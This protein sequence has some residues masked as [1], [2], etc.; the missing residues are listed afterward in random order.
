MP[1]PLSAVP[2][3]AEAIRP[4]G[5]AMAPGASSDEEAVA[6]AAAHNSNRMKHRFTGYTLPVSIWGKSSLQLICGDCN[7]RF[8]AR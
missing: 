7:P 1:S 6:N 4:V 8:H 5:N 3:L 2:V